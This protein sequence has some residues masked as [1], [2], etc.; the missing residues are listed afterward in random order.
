M[1]QE[2]LLGI[3]IEIN[4]KSTMKDSPFVRT[5]KGFDNSEFSRTILLNHQKRLE[6]PST[7]KLQQNIFVMDAFLLL[8][9]K[10]EFD[11]IVAE[12]KRVNPWLYDMLADLNSS[13]VEYIYNIAT[14]IRGSRQPNIKSEL[15]A[16]ARTVL[17]KY[18]EAEEQIKKKFT[19]VEFKKLIEE[20]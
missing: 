20:E 12:Y 5:K 13:P 2:K 10:P 14:C 17:R 9:N 1:K 16:C 15:M 19:P 8:I 7:T 3:S 11:H 6:L 18:P 4:K